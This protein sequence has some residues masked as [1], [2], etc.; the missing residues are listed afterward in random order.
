MQ[1]SLSCMAW[2]PNS[3]HAEFQATSRTCMALRQTKKK[4][5]GRAETRYNVKVVKL[6]LKFKAVRLPWHLEELTYVLNWNQIDCLDKHAC[7]ADSKR[8]TQPAGPIR[9]VT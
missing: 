7:T 6:Q 1:D 9:I 2:E 5:A 3:F 8:F 4:T